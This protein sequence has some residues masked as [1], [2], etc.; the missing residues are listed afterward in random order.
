MKEN[1]QHIF[2][3]LL[4]FIFY[5][6]KIVLFWCRYINVLYTVIIQVLA[7]IYNLYAMYIIF[8][9]SW[10]ETNFNRKYVLYNVVV[11]K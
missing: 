4:N 10:K 3:T 7:Y 8:A 1:S 6:R 2:S 9:A 11:Y 5:E